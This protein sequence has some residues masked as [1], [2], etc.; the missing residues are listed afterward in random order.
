MRRIVL[1]AL[2][3]TALPVVALAAGAGTAGAG[4]SATINADYIARLHERHG[5]HQFLAG[6]GTPGH[7]WA[8]YQRQAR[9]LRDYLHQVEVNRRRQDLVNRWQGVANCES[10]GNWHINTGNGHYGGL[11]FSLGTWQA[12]GGRGMPHQQEAWKQ[13]QVAERVRA[14]AGLG[15]W[16]HCGA[17]YG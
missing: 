12:Y 7:T 17:H 9:N 3:T 1:L 16:P 6:Q 10:G 15:A 4:R 2:L 13:A 8:E 11:Q 5:H 14:D